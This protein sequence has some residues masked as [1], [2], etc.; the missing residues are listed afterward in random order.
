MVMKIEF[1]SIQ[2]Y[3]VNRG[4][5]FVTRTLNH[6]NRQRSN[7]VWFHITKIKANYPE[8]AISLDTGLSKDIRLWY[9]IDS[10]GQK[11]TVNQ[12]WLDSVEIPDQKRAELINY[13]ESLWSK[14]DLP[15]PL[16]LDEITLKAVGQDRRN[17]L[18]EIY[19]SQITKQ[20]EEV[21]KQ[22]LVFQRERN[23]IIP[24]ATDR[25]RAERGIIEKIFAFDGFHGLP[26]SLKSIVRSCPRESRKNPLSHQEGGSDVVVAYSLGDAILYDWI[27]NVVLY[28]NSFERSNPEFHLHIQSI[29]GRFCEDKSERNIGVFCPLWERNKDGELKSD[30]EACLTRHQR[31]MDISH[32]TLHK[33]AINY[34]K[35][36]GLSNQQIENLPTLYKQYLKEKEEDTDDLVVI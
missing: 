8:I 28:I 14:T 6:E 9:E 34:W 25:F 3:D 5:G 7:N 35:N 22:E 30:I 33:E 23:I 11:P 16:W 20:Q 1:G 4:F 15:L 19:N 2:K 26:N 36:Y 21:K 10:E 27:K 12:V 13:I 29:Y 24:S 31:Q 17:N 18:R 32:K